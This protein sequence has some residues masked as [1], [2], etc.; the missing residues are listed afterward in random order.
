MVRGEE[1]VRRF[2]EA[3]VDPATRFAE[4][5]HPEGTLYQQGMERP[6]T[7]DEIPAHVAAILS[8][9][10]DQRIVAQ[11]WAVNGDDVFIEWTAS[12]TFRG[13]AV[14]WSGASRFTLRDGLVLEEIAY[15]DTLPLRAL[16]DPSLKRTGLLELASDA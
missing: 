9:I 8:L 14:S 2:E 16:I 1:F 6:I 7:K 12:A 13:E 5:F 10:P 3:W 11:R 4:L 15:F